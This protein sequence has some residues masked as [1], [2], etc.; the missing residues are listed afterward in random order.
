MVAVVVTRGKYKSHTSRARFTLVTESLTIIKNKIEYNILSTHQHEYICLHYY[1]LRIPLKKPRKTLKSSYTILDSYKYYKLHS[2]YN[3]I[4][5]LQFNK[6]KE[7]V[8]LV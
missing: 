7:S 3:V 2:K 4:T 8:K 6:V 1:I 5:K